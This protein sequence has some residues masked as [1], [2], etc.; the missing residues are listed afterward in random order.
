MQ[1]RSHKWAY[2]IPIHRCTST[3]TSTHTNT[4]TVI[5]WEDISDCSNYSG[6]PL[7]PHVQLLRD[8]TFRWTN[9]Q[10]TDVF[11]RLQC[12]LFSLRSGV[13]TAQRF[14]TP[15]F[16]EALNTSSSAVIWV[17]VF[18]G[19][20]VKSKK[21]PNETKVYRTVVRWPLPPCDWT[22]IMDKGFI[23]IFTLLHDIY[24]TLQSRFDS[25][26]YWHYGDCWG[27]GGIK[28]TMLE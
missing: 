4:L 7:F 26:Y 6:F 21:T 17:F 12:C 25:H 19:H 10:L 9:G 8:A 27:G 22:Y 1:F 3:H 28:W 5:Q 14:S 11:V 13:W 2:Y 24:S 23:D 16:L 15:F 20:N 18:C